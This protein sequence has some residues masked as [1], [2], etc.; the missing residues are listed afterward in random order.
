MFEIAPWVLPILAS[1]LTLGF[2]NFTTKG[3]VQ[4]NAVVPVVFLSTLSG[5]AFYLLVC[6]LSGNF[7]EY[8]AC[9]LPVFGL[10]ML[11]A[12][13]V[14]ASWLCGY[15]AMRELPISIAVPIR[16]SAPLWTFLGSIVLYHEVPTWF[17]GLGMLCIFAGYFL[18]SVL[19]QKEGIS[20][21][22]HK[23]MHMIFL[24][25]L[26]GAGSA[27]YDKY[28]LNIRHISQNH[29]QFYFSIG[30]VLI[31]GLTLLLRH[32]FC[33]KHH[34]LQWR[35]Q[36]PV[37]GILLI[38]ADYLYFRAVSMPDIQI[39]VLSLIRRSGC[40]V[41]FTIGVICYKEKNIRRKAI[42][43]AM[44]LAGVAILVLMKH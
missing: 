24:A 33:E 16:T 22:R 21:R 35:W 7:M 44:I 41:A 34:K 39:S 19:G 9:P 8:A 4:N 11:K 30:L 3:A 17:Q 36:I 26:L 31:F 20:F 15:Y 13:I 5:T 42:A 25:T 40:V 38:A 43:L 2:Y 14:A 27:L 12:L 1:A 10:V 23:G 6:L 37:T 29:V 32:F 18:F 28:L